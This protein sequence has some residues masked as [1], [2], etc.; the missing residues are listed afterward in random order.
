MPSAAWYGACSTPIEDGHTDHDKRTKRTRALL[1]SISA[2]LAVGSTQAAAQVAA[3][4]V[5]NGLVT[6]EARGVSVRQI[7]D[8]WVRTAGVTVVNGEHLPATPVDLS[9]SR[10]P[11]R[12]ALEILLRGVSGYILGVRE[13]RTATA[14]LIDRIFLLPTSNAPRTA[15][16]PPVFLPAAGSGPHDEAVGFDAAGP[17]YAGA[18]ATRVGRPAEVV[19]AFQRPV[20]ADAISPPVAAVPARPPDMPIRFAEGVDENG[21][22]VRLPT[23]PTADPLPE[24]AGATVPANPFGV[25]T[26]S[27]RPGVIPP[28]QKPSQ[29]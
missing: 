26:G 25:T 20:D 22:R 3:L 7:L 19:D 17:Q 14:S 29:P 9:L 4:Q 15:T 1:I 6:L 18:A 21:D 2:L 11:E 24:A 8:V 5:E 13:G 10:V 23:L 12:T 27:L 28:A 16:A